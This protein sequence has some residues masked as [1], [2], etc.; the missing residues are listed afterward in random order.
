MKILAINGSHRGRT[1]YTEFLVQKLFEG[2]SAAGAQC[3]SVALADLSIRRCAGCFVCQNEDHRLR[4]IYDGQDDAGVVF[5]KMRAADLIVFATP[6][7]VFSM[8]SLLKTLIDRYASTAQCGEFRLSRCGLFFHE[9]DERVCSKP[10]ATIVCQDNVENETHRNIVSYFR[11]YARFMD[12][13]YVGSLV[14]KQSA[15][16]GHGRDATS[17]ERHPALRDIYRAWS[18]AG[19]ELAVA[20]RI[21]RRVERA[22]NR[23]LTAIPLFVRPLSRL[24]GFRERIAGEVRKR[25]EA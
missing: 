17:L 3:E 1:G 23:S 5:D 18:D 25:M 8:S 22:A 14:R 9:I 20:G 13:R 11:T 2:A 15:A 4:C 10:F 12:A 24:P 21:S 19:R 7:Y 6:V 16:A